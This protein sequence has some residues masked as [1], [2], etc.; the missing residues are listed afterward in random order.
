VTVLALI[1]HAAVLGVEPKP[2]RGRPANA[3]YILED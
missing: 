3:E 1:L 2:L